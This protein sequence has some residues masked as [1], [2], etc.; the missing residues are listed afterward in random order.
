MVTVKQ[1]RD[2][3]DRIEA[4]LEGF[5]SHLMAKPVGDRPFVLL[6]NMADMLEEIARLDAALAKSDETLEAIQDDS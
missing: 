1:Y 4:Q 5:E 2:V 6:E 3:W